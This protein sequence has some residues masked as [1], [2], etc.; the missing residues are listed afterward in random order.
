[1]MAVYQSPV[2]CHSSL[3]SSSGVHKMEHSVYAGAR[4]VT[5]LVPNLLNSHEFE[6]Q[7]APCACYARTEWEPFCG[8]IALHPTC[9]RQRSKSAMAEGALRKEG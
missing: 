5:K 1:M 8:L 9:C 3:G 6:E 4:R 7:I 2:C